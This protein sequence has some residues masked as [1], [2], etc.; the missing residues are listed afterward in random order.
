MIDDCRIGHFTGDGVHLSHI[1]CF[2]VRHSM[3]FSNR[4]AGLM[5]DGWDA[6]IID[7]W[8][9]GNGTAGIYAGPT[10]A[11]V[12]ATGNRVEWN[13][14]AGFLVESGDSWNITGNF[15]DRT[16]GPAL[17]FGSRGGVSTMTVTGNIFRRS[18]KP[19]GRPE[20]ERQN[21][22]LYIERT[23]NLSVTGNSFRVGRDDGG[24]GTFSPA[25]G[26]I[27]DGCSQSVV[28]NNSWQHGAML[29][30]CTLE[31]CGG[32]VLVTGNV[33]EVSGELNH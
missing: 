4:G 28:A 17:R 7:N 8:F 21:S 14:G 23:S 2:S 29:E 9:T 22:H 1:W 11:S 33:G 10:A 24:K 6:F 30:N 32:D 20:G 16:C 31:N 5:M 3:L 13:R 25:F 12:T 15:F 26:V 18:G 19:E 27:L